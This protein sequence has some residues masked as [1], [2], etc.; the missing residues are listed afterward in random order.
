MNQ[1]PR[2]YPVERGLIERDDCILLV[3]DL[4]DGFLA[5][6]DEGRAARCLERVRFLVEV[7]NR[8]EVPLFVTVED[9]ARNGWTT[10]PVS[11]LFDQDLV[12][13]GKRVFSLCG[14]P[15]LA[16]A[17][18][19]QRRRTAVLIG[20]E[21]DVCIL[22]SAVGLGALGFRAVIVSDATAAPGEEHAL[23]LARAAAL[24]AELI[25]AKGLF[26]EWT[27]SLDGLAALKAG[28]P[29]AP[30]AGSLL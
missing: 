30:P 29:I 13:H 20:L 18:L 6:L 27:R 8:L 10:A 15:D 16:A 25:H 22:H 2:P 28:S 7:A 5:K 9:P 24:G 3:I 17:M 14:Q 19:R 23:G 1:P 4:Q 21:T 12:Q 26:Y 11:A